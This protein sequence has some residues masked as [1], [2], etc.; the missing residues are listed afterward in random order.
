LLDL[1]V[2]IDA[3]CRW[4]EFPHSLELYNKLVTSGQ[5]SG[6]FPA[7]GYTTLY[8]VIKQ[9]I[10]EQ[11]TRAVMENFRRRLALLPFTTR[12]AELAHRFQMLDL[13]DACIAATALEGRCDAIATRNTDDFNT[14]PIPARLPEELLTSL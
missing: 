13:E 4:R 10:S 1:N 5:D 6:A 14:S 8:Y 7:C 2:L 9:M 12:T 3:A 11:R